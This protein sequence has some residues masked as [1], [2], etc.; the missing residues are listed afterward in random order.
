MLRVREAL[1]DAPTS[2]RAAN[3]ELADARRVGR[4]ER[5]KSEAETPFGD[6]PARGQSIPPQLLR[7]APATAGPACWR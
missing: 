5:A 3:D 7:R 2:W 4:R 6:D 1:P